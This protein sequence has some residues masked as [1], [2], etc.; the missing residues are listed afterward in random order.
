M[1]IKLEDYLSEEERKDICASAF[2]E[3]C[4]D[5]FRKDHERIFTNAAYS[6]VTANV[7]RIFDGK[8]ADILTE[9]TVKV[10]DELTTYTVFKRKDYWEKDDSAGFRKLNEAIDQNKEKLIAKISTMIEGMDE[11]ELAD[12]V[13]ESVKDI[14][15]TKLFGKGAV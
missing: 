15:D 8:M 11:E 4:E 2:R 1:E 6:I 10:I 5:K 14:L 12:R 13:K 7:D 9:K 3:F